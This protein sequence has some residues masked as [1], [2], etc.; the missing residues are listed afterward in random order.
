MQILIF[1]S[2]ILS[3]S[4]SIG[5]DFGCF[6]LHMFY[7]VNNFSK[8]KIFRG[9]FKN[10][11]LL[12]ILVSFLIPP[13]C[14]FPLTF[15]SFSIEHRQNFFKITPYWNGNKS[16]HQLTTA[17]H[18]VHGV[19]ATCPSLIFPCFFLFKTNSKAAWCIQWVHL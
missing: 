9:L 14:L 2:Q 12:T 1:K 13:K 19:Q 4:T 7:Q 5:W 6:V 3:V 11:L 17:V 18:T 10:V 8:K 15:F 16:T